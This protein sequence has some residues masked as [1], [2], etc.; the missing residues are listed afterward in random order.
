MSLRKLRLVKGW[1]VAGGWW[2]A[3][4]ESDNFL[5]MLVGKYLISGACWGLLIHHSL[6]VYRANITSLRTKSL[7]MIT[8]FLAVA[9]L[10]AFAFVAN[11]KSC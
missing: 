7:S 9:H 1:L 5:A 6:W 3:A 4:T 10:S 8:G 11:E 2:Q